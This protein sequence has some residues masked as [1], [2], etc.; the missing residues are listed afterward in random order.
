MT[1]RKHTG[2]RGRT[3]SDPYK[4]ADG[5]Y[6]W[7]GT[8]GPKGSI[9]QKVHNLGTSDEREAKIKIKRLLA[10]GGD[11]APAAAAAPVTI[12]EFAEEWI[13]RREKLKLTT[14]PYER[15]YFEQIWS[16][17]VGKKAFPEVR[18][19]DLQEVLDRLAIGEILAPPRREGAEPTRYGR[20]TI[21]H[22]RA[23]AKRLW[24]GA[25]QAELVQKN[26]A[27]LTELPISNDEDQKKDRA[28]L[29]D[30]EIAQLVRCPE[31]DAEIKVL[32]LISR[33][34]GGLRAGDLTAMHWSVFS[35]L[36]GFST[37]TFR[38]RKTRKKQPRTETHVV[39]EVVR[40]YLD[41]WHERH[42][43]PTSGP[44]FPSR[45]GPRAGQQKMPSS[46]G[47]ASR[48]RRALLKA[49]VT[50]HELHHATDLTLPTDYHSTRRAF[51]TAA[52]GSGLTE[53]QVMDLGSW[54]DSKL[55]R[56]Y[57]DK[58]KPKQ[59]PASAVPANLQG[60]ADSLRKPIKNPGS[61]SERD[62]G[63]EPVTSSLGSL[64]ST[65]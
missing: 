42:G 29:D 3:G 32:L 33:T 37:C 35:P 45:R 61:F 11:A 21:K 46:A 4:G 41:A 24:K 10:T 31:V 47:Y 39:P 64:R 43:R 26:T 40:A 51:G 52:I 36:P 50:R 14:A 5:I 56:R 9:K 13:L 58:V 53:Q 34:V 1:E 38:R 22:I 6:R 57:N 49:G 19:G 7:R 59:L 25:M 30:D 18:V 28:Q 20:E 48:L 17:A 65:N 12:A 8:V 55:V 2:G 63:L 16:P 27:D 62:T 54:S 60:H 15:R 23:T 44:I